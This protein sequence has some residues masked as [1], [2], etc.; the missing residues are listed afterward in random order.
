[1][2]TLTLTAKG[3]ATLSKKV[4]QHLGVKPGG[5]IELDL[6]PDGRAAICAAR[7]AGSINDFIGA[8]AGKTDKVAT[9]EEINEAAALGWAGKV[10][11]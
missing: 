7:P 1:M 9:I 3:Q 4:L 8:L 11:M 6:L 10:K 2:I 5:K